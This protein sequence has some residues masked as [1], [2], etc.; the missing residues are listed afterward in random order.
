MALAA[1][2]GPTGSSPSPLPR[3]QGQ[4]LTQLTCLDE[5]CAP[6]EPAQPEA[7]VVHW[8]TSLTAAQ[9]QSKA[10]NRPIFLQFSE[11]PG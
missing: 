5:H 7:G 8:L 2:A 9:A 4:L 1:A 3:R 10:L 11:I 6:T